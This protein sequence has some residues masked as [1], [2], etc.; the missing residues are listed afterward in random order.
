MQ[1][2]AFFHHATGTASYLVFND[3]GHAVIIDSVLDF[4]SSSGTVT[5]DFV[6]RQLDFLTQRQLT[7][8][9]ILETHAHAD[10]ISAAA[11]LKQKTGAK[12]AIGEGITRAQAHFTSVFKPLPDPNSGNLAF[13]LLLKDGDTLAF[14][15]TQITAIHTPGHTC[16]SM[17]FIIGNHVFV[18]DTLF[19]PDIGTARCDFPGG[20]AQTLWQSIEKL[21]A[22]PPNMK[23]WVCHDYPPQGRDIA[24]STTVQQSKATNIHIRGKTRQQFIALRETR[25]SHLAVP[26]LLYPAIQINLWGGQMPQPE[27]NGHR[28]IKIPLS[29]QALTGVLL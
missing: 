20:S 8:D 4:S 14:G 16:D 12:T 17:S 2:K 13:D 25:D 9:Y 7:L 21:H 5:T 3:T 26:E 27:T 11:Y 1:V 22:L 24:L 19:M 10:H 29:A 15:N 6:E 28:Y 23:I 18:G